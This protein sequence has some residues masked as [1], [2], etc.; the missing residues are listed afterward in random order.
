M[1]LNVTGLDAREVDNAT[2]TT[3]YAPGYST[4][5]SG[6]WIGSIAINRLDNG[7]PDT[8][9]YQCSRC[10][11]TGERLDMLRHVHNDHPEEF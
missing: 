9:L 4:Q 10:D 1:A 11:F 2:T 3:T 7:D 8:T 6:F 5:Y